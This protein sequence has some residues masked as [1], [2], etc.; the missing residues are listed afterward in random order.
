MKRVILAA[1]LLTGLYATVLATFGLLDLVFAAIVSVAAL[2]VWRD[3]L[4]GGRPAAVPRLS[5]RILAFVPFAGA[6]LRDVVTGTWQVALIVVHLR[7][8]GSPGLVEVPFGPRTTTGVAVSGLVSGLSPG[9]V[10][11]ATSDDVM[12][13]HVIDASDPDA[14]RARFDAFYRRYQRK[15]FP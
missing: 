7:P 11:V 8:L 4:F 3:L 10:L 15:V 9:T 12:L 6:V 1:V 14:V 2:Y 13:F 5:R